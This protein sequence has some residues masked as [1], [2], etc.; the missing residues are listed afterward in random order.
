MVYRRGSI[1]LHT[2]ISANDLG[3]IANTIKNYHQ[4]VDTWVDHDKYHV[5]FFEC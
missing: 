2:M 4:G 5:P 1:L 3:V